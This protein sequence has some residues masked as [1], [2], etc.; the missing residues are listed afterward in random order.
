MD[1]DG[2]RNLQHCLWLLCHRVPGRH[3]RVAFDR[4]AKVPGTLAVHRDDRRSV[5]ARLLDRCLRPRPP[6]ANRAGWISGETIWP[7][8]NG[9]GCGQRQFAAPV[10]NCQCWQRPDM[11][12]T[13]RVGLKICV[14]R[15]HWGSRGTTD[16][17]WM[18]FAAKIPFYQCQFPFKFQF[19]TIVVVM[20][21]TAPPPTRPD[22]APKP[23]LD[24]GPAPPAPRKNPE[25]FEPDWP[26]SRPTPQPKATWSITANGH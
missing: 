23:D 16:L 11:V 6:L 14:P 13:I 20:P 10:R 19:P 1:V 2:G 5:R 9:L 25:P 26:D 12:G 7:N 8:R 4:N 24:P 22:T 3:L 15:K 21:E 18:P 17:T